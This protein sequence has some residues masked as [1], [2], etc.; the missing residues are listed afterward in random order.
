ACKAPIGVLSFIEGD[1]VS[2]RATAGLTLSGVPRAESFCTHTIEQSDI[3]IVC[4][5]LEDARFRHSRL[6]ALDPYVRFYAGVPLATPDGQ[7]FGALGVMDHTRRSLGRGQREALRALARQAMRH[8]ELRRDTKMLATNSG[9]GRDV[10]TGLPDQTSFKRLLEA[11]IAAAPAPAALL[12]VNLDRFRVINETL[13]FEAGDH[14][15]QH[16]ARRLR[17]CLGEGD[18]AARFGSDEFALLVRGI[19]D[20]DGAG[21]VAQKILDAL[22]FPFKIDEQELFIT[23]SVGVSLYPHDGQNAA[24]L[25]KSGGIALTRA[26]E[27]DGNS[28]QLYTAGRTTKALK[29]LVLESSLP[30]GL[31]REEFRLFYQPQ[32]SIRTGL[33][34]GVEA[35]V[36]WEHPELGFLGPTEFIPLAE[37]NGM[38]VRLGEWILRTA[39]AQNKTWQEMGFAPLR[40][41]INLAARQFQQP[42]V[43]EMVARILHATGLDA[44]HLELEVT[45]SSIMPNAEQ[46]IKKLNDLKSMGLQLSIDDFGTGYSSLNYLKR[47]PIDTLKIDQS[48]V[49]D[50]STDPDDAS[51]VRAIITL[52]HSLKLNVI[53]EGVETEE[54][55]SYLRQLKCDEMQGYW[56]SYPVAAKEVEAILVERQRAINAAQRT[57]GKMAA[58]LDR[59]TA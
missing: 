34:V 11:Q 33:V 8:F 16:V 17:A 58:H 51:I 6:V 5:A 13:G 22:S 32:L 35:L 7:K 54:Q 44:R 12:F 30:R 50:I 20:A 21:A 56:F 1:R 27:Q 47:F 2:F 39:C 23:A 26:K 25:L 49:R 53:A 36:R 52:A 3:L 31:E 18:T 55:F 29:E 28:Y 4:D 57:S 38:I 19:D 46:A 42:D 41:S 10:L 15:L 14:L 45:E 9:A 37:E 59:I 48:F 43:V 40:M 24:T